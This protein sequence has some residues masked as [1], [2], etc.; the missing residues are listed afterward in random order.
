MAVTVAPG[1]SMVVVTVSVPVVPGIVTVLVR[2]SVSVVPGK[3]TVVVTVSV[4]VG[5]GAVVV[6]VTVV[7]TV[8]PGPTVGVVTGVLVIV[9]VVGVVSGGV[10]VG[11]L[12]EVVVGVFVHT[13]QVVTVDVEVTVIVAGALAIMAG[14]FGGFALFLKVYAGGVIVVEVLVSAPKIGDG[15]GIN[16]YAEELVGNNTVG[17]SNRNSAGDV[18]VSATAEYA[19]ALVGRLVA[20]YCILEVISNNRRLTD[21]PRFRNSDCFKHCLCYCHIFC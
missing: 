15:P 14:D 5:P 19:V 3:P 21:L 1:K 13:G 6:T 10:I 2:V 17:V 11:V 8:D 20:A 9:D 16:Q 12:V 18:D 4:S 7:V